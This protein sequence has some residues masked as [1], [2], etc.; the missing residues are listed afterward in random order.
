MT[1]MN[2]VDY[3]FTALRKLTMN[4]Q[5]QEEL[6]AALHVALIVVFVGVMYA[7]YQVRSDLLEAIER[8]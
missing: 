8:K 4:A 6:Y 2:K 7:L 1:T 3:S 5:R